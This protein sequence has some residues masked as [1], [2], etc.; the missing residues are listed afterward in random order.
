MCRRLYYSVLQMLMMLTH[1]LHGCCCRQVAFFIHQVTMVGD[2]TSLAVGGGDHDDRR[3]R[4]LASQSVAGLLVYR[5]DKQ[6]QLWR[7]VL[8]MLVHA[9]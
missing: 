5:P 8:Y 9:G 1:V 4:R 7:F 3:Q 2:A 6:R